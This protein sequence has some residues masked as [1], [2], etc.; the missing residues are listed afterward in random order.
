MEKNLS[1]AQR[2]QLLMNTAKEDLLIKKEM[3]N[4]FQQ[5]KKTLEDSISKMTMCLTSLGNAIANGMQML[6]L[7]L[8][9]QSPNTRPTPQTPQV[10][11]PQASTYGGF[12]SSPT[13]GANSSYTPLTTRSTPSQLNRIGIDEVSQSS[14]GQGH[15]LG[16]TQAL[17]EEDSFRY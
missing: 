1:Q 12:T 6:A 9:G 4:S 11:H 5:S 15:I 8:S 10:Y 13:Y 7:A 16:T 2:D 17:F 3:M 14:P